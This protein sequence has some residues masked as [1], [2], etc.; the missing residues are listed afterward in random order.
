MENER[1]DATAEPPADKSDDYE[2]PSLT[3]LG[4]FADLTK[5]VVPTSTDGV[6]PGSVL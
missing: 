3:P 5:G 6:L 2:M 1:R 4:S